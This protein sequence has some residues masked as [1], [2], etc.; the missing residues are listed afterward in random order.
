MLIFLNYQS[1][2]HSFGILVFMDFW[3]S[4]ND[5]TPVFLFIYISVFDYK[6]KFLNNFFN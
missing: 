2:G 1:L 5:F 3:K 4:L 6:N